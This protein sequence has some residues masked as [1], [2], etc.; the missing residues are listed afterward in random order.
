MPDTYKVQIKPVEENHERVIEIITEYRG[1]NGQQAAEQLA[2]EG[3]TVLGDLNREAA[4]EVHA[5]LEEAGADARIV[6]DEETSEDEETPPFI[7]FGKIT[8][9]SGEPAAGVTV[10]AFDR[11]L[12]SQQLLGEATANDDGVYQIRYSRDQFR[13]AEK[14]RADL[15]MRAFNAVG[16]ELEVDSDRDGIIFQAQ[17]QEEVNLELASDKMIEPSEYERLVRVLRPLLEDVPLAELTEADID[18]LAKDTGQEKKRIRFLAQDADLSQE[19]NV[20]ASVF[21]GFARQGLGL[22][23]GEGGPRLDLPT[24]LEQDNETLHSNLE[25]AL[26]EQIIP[27]RLGDVLDDIIARLASLRAERREQER[28]TWP[29]HELTGRL[30]NESMDAPLADYTVRATDMDAQPE[31]RNLGRDIT[32]E[33]GQFSFSY[34]IPP[35]ASATPRAIKLT[36]R[37]QSGEEIATREERVRPDQAQEV[38]LRIT[39]PEP[40]V[41]GDDVQVQDL[42]IGLSDETVAA[43]EEKEV[44][45]LADV[46]SFADLT[47]IDGIGETRAQELRAHADLSVLPSDNQTRSTLIE[48]GYN[49]PLDI[50]RTPRSTFSRSIGEEIE[51]ADRIHRA[52]QAVERTVKNI[53]SEIR[54]GEANSFSPE[55]L[56]ELGSVTLPDDI[57]FLCDCRD[58]ESA[59][60]PAAYLAD[61]TQYVLNQVQEN[62]QALTLDKLESLFY[63]PFGD[64]PV[65]CEAVTAEVRQVRI[66]IEVLLRYLGEDNIQFLSDPDSSGG[67]YRKQAYEILLNQIGTSRQELR[68]AVASDDDER[69]SLADRLGI[70]VDHLDRL[71]F[72]PSRPP[73]P[74]LGISPRLSERDLEIIFGLR[75]FTY[76]NQQNQRVTLPDPLRD[77][78][79]SRLLRWRIAHLRQQWMQQDHPTDAYLEEQLPLI[80]PDVITP[81]DFRTPDTDKTD[82]FKIWENRR[83]W[84]DAR[85]DDLR[86]KTNTVNVDNTTVTVPNVEAM[87]TD[88]MRQPVSYN[89]ADGNETN[90]TPWG[91]NAPQSDT[92]ADML[93]KL[94]TGENAEDTRN[95]LSDELHLTVESFT[96]LVQLWQ[97][98]Q[99]WTADQRYPEV[100]EEEQR[101]IRSILVQAQK[102][103]FYDTWI[104]EEDG[105]ILG[106]GTFWMSLREPEQGEWSSALNLPQGTPFI[107][108]ER[109]DR[110][111]L[112]EPTFG[113]PAIALWQ[114]RRRE[115]DE[116]QAHLHDFYNQQGKG[117]DDVLNEVYGGPPEGTDWSDYFSQHAD[118]SELA[119]DDAEALR[120]LKAT[121]DRATADPTSP[122][123][124]APPSAE[125]LETVFAMLTT[126]WK[127]KNK[128]GTSGTSNESWYTE[129]DKENL[130]TYWKVRKARLP[131]WRAD[132]PDRQQWQQALRRRSQRP[133]IDPDLLIP[134]EDLAEPVS[135]E[136]AYNLWQ[137]RQETLTQDVQDLQQMQANTSLVNQVNNTTDLSTISESLREQLAAYPVAELLEQGDSQALD[138]LKNYLSNDVTRLHRLVEKAIGVS[139]KTLVNLAE[140]EQNGNRI[141]DRLAQLTLT[142][143]AFDFLINVHQRAARG[144]ILNEPTWQE[145]YHLLVAVMKQRRWAE[146]Q[147]EERPDFVF[148]LDPKFRTDLR[149][150]TP[151]S[152]LRTAFQDQN[153]ALSQDVTIIT[154]E[155]GSRWQLR[156]EGNNRIYII[157]AGEATLRVYLQ[158]GTATIGAGT[159]SIVL[160]GA[161][162]LSPEHFRLAERTDVIDRFD[163]E[164]PQ[165]WRM[166]LEAMR[167]WR[168]TLEARIK[169]R[170]QIKAALREAVSQAEE[171]TLTTLRDAL[172][173]QFE[174]PNTDAFFGE[175]AEWA[176]K[177]LLI[178][179]E[180][181]S[182]RQTTRVSQATETLQ[183]LLFALHTGQ[184]TG[185]LADLDFQISDTRFEQEWKWLGTYPAW[186]AAMGLQLYPENMLRPG[187]RRWQTPLFAD[188]VS[189]VQSQNLSSNG[190]HRQVAKYQTYFRDVTSLELQAACW[191]KVDQE[192]SANDPRLFPRLPRDTPL[193]FL[194]AQGGSSTTGYRL[195]WSA[196]NPDEQDPTKAQTFWQE[197]PHTRFESPGP[198]PMTSQV[199]AA[200]PYISAHG[201]YICV[202]IRRLKEGNWELVLTR[203]DLTTT[204]WGQ[205]KPTSLN[206]PD[207]L[208]INFEA[209]PVQSDSKDTRP[210]RI[211]L[212]DGGER[213]FIRQLNEDASAFAEASDPDPL[214]DHKRDQLT[215]PVLP[216]NNVTRWGGHNF[217]RLA[218]VQPLAAFYEALSERIKLIFYD[219]E[220]VRRARLLLNDQWHVDVEDEILAKGRAIRSQD[221]LGLSGETIFWNHGQT[222]RQS[223]NDLGTI[224]TVYYTLRAVPPVCGAARGTDSRIPYQTID[225]T[226][227]AVEIFA[228]SYSESSGFDFMGIPLAPHISS[229]ENNPDKLLFGLTPA[230]LEGADPD[231]RRFVVALAYT[232]QQL[233]FENHATQQVNRIYLDEAY[234]F[235]PMLVALYLRREGRYTEALE[236]YRLVYAYTENTA[237]FP[238]KF[239]SSNGGNAGIALPS[240]SELDGRLN[241]HSIAK[242]RPNTATKYTQFTLFSII[243]CLLDYADDEFSQDTGESIQRARTL[244]ETALDLLETEEL[245]Q[246]R[247]RCE[248]LTATVKERVWAA[249]DGT[250]DAGRF[251]H[252]GIGG[253]LERK[254]ARI[255]DMDKLKELDAQLA[256]IDLEGQTREERIKQVWD[257]VSEVKGKPTRPTALGA[258]LEA[259]ATAEQAVF[260]SLMAN[261]SIAHATSNVATE[262]MSATIGANGVDGTSYTSELRDVTLPFC[263]PANPVLKSLR[264]RANLNLKKIRTCRNFAGMKRELAPYAAPTGVESA[265]PGLGGDGFT[266]PGQRNIEPTDYRYDTL[267]A[268]T[269]ELV[270]LAQK[271]EASFLSAIESGDAEAYKLLQARQDIELARAGVRLQSLRVSKAEDRVDLIELQKERAALRANRYGNWVS[272]LKSFEE[273]DIYKYLKTARD[274]TMASAVVSGV[275]SVAAAI[276]GGIAG[277]SAGG[278]LGS[279]LGAGAGAAIGALRNLG[280]AASALQGIASWYRTKANI[281]QIRASRQRM[282]RR[283]KLQRDLAKQD[284][285]IASQQIEIAEANV[286]IVEQQREIAEIETNH[287][288][289]TIEFLRDEQFTTYELYDWMADVLEGVYRYFLQQAASMARLAERQLAFERQELPQQ[290]IQSGYWRAPSEGQTSIS[291][292]EQPPERRGL[293]GSARL[294]QDI[295][296]LDQYAFRTDE[297]KLHVSKTMSL[298]E[299]APFELQQFRQT[300]V[301]TFDTPEELFD[302][303]YPGHYLRL[304]RNVSVSIIALTPPHAGVKAMLSNDGISRVVAEGPPFRTRV[305]RRDPESIALSSTQSE[306]GVFQLRPEGEMLLP[307]EKV[308][309]D[310][311]W[312]LQMPQAANPFDY[313]TIADVL[314]TINYTALQSYTYRQQVIKRLDPEESG[315]QAYSFND[316]FAD[317]WYDLHN[318]EQSDTPMTVRFETRR[319]DFPPHLQDIE[320]EHVLLYY[321]AQDGVDT[322]ELKT[323]LTFT[324]HAGQGAVGGKAPPAEQRISTRR[325]N[326]SSWLPMV[327]KP[328]DGAWELS[329]PNTAQVRRLFKEEKIEDILF[330]ITYVGRTP[331]W[332]Q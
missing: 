286:D 291:R 276:G 148:A 255:N 130:R 185:E 268:R 156:D 319:A 120:T 32:D 310:T 140:H 239:R 134:G 238:F 253:S 59:V 302:R 189:E 246:T 206:L 39:P 116:Y 275:S 143:P 15:L 42:T 51:A 298:A 229:D 108:P 289:Q 2:E 258:S 77:I 224:H 251:E 92:F 133:I 277:A 137:T 244:Y 168:D 16:T 124:P 3:G 227:H 267:I 154:Q 314:L 31:P 115:L 209:I 269:K 131:R 65:S 278:P 150:D 167:D 10:R 38:E 243:Q 95:T 228:A 49:S 53:A 89:D 158:A 187:L 210:P 46:R 125:Q 203:F 261:S 237:A 9:S 331:D 202:F 281:A 103:A 288:E 159:L 110:K 71:I 181:S 254:I 164:S 190:L 26:S 306:T 320:I 85:L 292:D 317:Q 34:R 72:D 241:P 184:E 296:Q 114:Q 118:A 61:L 113:A 63:Q 211:I 78:D 264:Q 45:S 146:W 301:L 153:V 256:T 207:T 68:L 102:R 170:D 67:E 171:E 144:V 136:R 307:F 176:S 200:V 266:P 152:D 294:L 163:D 194:F 132:R 139:L 177:R 1:S 106:P 223:L 5:Q 128:Y 6:P 74:V 309:V 196:Y 21:Y 234:Y 93:R 285:R 273:T 66:C 173:E 316:V 135:G 305:I 248:T 160:Y 111:E 23:T 52:A 87:F 313:D 220:Q 205:G 204:E 117:F 97:K 178:D 35:E 119:L 213:V 208:G 180:M 36:V 165:Q 247:H 48:K 58:C 172:I 43:L 84:V 100:T 80:D 252:Y 216:V 192:L 166:S 155:A 8:H 162:T 149:A 265:A 64:L 312:Q 13:R 236:W 262:A 240:Q 82:A 221:F 257:T 231:E 101:E 199:V 188:I 271:I 245:K 105:I 28:A 20:A 70:A 123:A 161:V 293:T 98:V 300:G 54:T 27:A 129:E 186:R 183:T 322:E 318:P 330:I 303:D 284:Q 175:K 50:A 107:D 157:A 25:M 287:A 40:R 290:F 230:A 121:R 44:R 195:Y 304:I 212:S 145:V 94:N 62:D 197:I 24:L 126:A 270:N 235:L 37:A 282:K 201:K 76:Y 81:D 147:M 222:H 328:L 274:L 297:R 323:T 96:R 280:G 225:I 214:F 321:V 191:A 41:P 193:L 11:D 90:T 127:R 19:H 263:I 217:K 56:G 198:E 104:A 233:D 112:P 47:T 215:I 29:Q 324:P 329:L 12:R 326:G 33:E 218:R 83:E 86:S 232:L 57:P 122:K 17:R 18:F 315:E 151:S 219:G 75:A 169:Q 7:V 142:R 250:G 73:G 55:L 272:G 22:I 109:V 91:G 325:G 279:T 308:G 249:I 299:L 99:K 138:E 327:G 174:Q 4:E 311:T 283:W 88:I 260:R 14:G 60:S 182:C 259:H 179:T 332:P 295:Y 242:R 30:L 69:Q 79:D 141:D 226:G